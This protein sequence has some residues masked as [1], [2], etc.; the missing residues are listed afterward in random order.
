MT[1]VL[2][3]ISKKSIV[4]LVLN[5]KLGLLTSSKNSF[6][7]NYYALEQNINRYRNN[8]EAKYHC[9]QYAHQTSYLILKASMRDWEALN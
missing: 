4:S 7:R 1:F 5:Y 2:S 3:I 8:C 9:I 6:S